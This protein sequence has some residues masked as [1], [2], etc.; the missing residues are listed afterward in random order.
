MAI[1]VDSVCNCFPA[2]AFPDGGGVGGNDTG[3]VETYSENKDVHFHV[4]VEQSHLD[5]ILNPYETP[6]N[7]S[8]TPA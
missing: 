7:L 2:I 4:F 1:N 8:Q 6:L 3:A 5:G